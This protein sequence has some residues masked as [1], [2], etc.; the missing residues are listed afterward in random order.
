MRDDRAP[1][2]RGL[3]GGRMRA[4]VPRRKAEVDE[5]EGLWWWRWC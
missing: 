3:D 5:D 1:H 4:L 2:L